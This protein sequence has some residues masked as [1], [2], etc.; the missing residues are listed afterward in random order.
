MGTGWSHKYEQL[1]QEYGIPHGCLPVSSEPA[2]V[3]RQIEEIVGEESRK[4]I[5]LTIAKAAETCR[6]RTELMWK[7]VLP[8]IEG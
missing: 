5:V 2:I 6:A 3:R 7:K 1:F 4:E 8:M